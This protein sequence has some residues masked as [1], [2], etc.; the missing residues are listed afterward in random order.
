MCPSQVIRRLHDRVTWLEAHE[1]WFIKVLDL[2]IF[3]TPQWVLAAEA[4]RAHYGGKVSTW[5]N[6]NG[7][8]EALNALGCYAYEHPQNAY[9][10]FVDDAPYLQAK[11]L[12]HPLLPRSRAVANDV[13]LDS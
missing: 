8:G 1:N 3:W 5:I 7:E 13:Q 12:A 9:P 4:W 10:V 6:V 11:E 2:F